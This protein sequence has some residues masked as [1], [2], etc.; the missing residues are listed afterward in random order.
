MATSQTPMHS[1]TPAKVRV[2][3]AIAFILP[4]VGA[5]LYHMDGLSQIGQMR[6]VISLGRGFIIISLLA[7]LFMP[8]AFRRILDSKR[9]GDEHE[10][11]MRARTF[12]RAYK[13]HVVLSIILVVIAAISAHNGPGGEDMQLF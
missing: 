8:R 6:I 2:L 7:M 10:L 3:A 9:G 1:W 12:S 5:A 11:F 13:F 4:I